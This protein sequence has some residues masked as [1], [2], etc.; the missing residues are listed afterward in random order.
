MVNVTLSLHETVWK[1]MKAHNEIRWSRTVE[2][3]IEGKLDAFDEAQ[4]LAS[5]S[6]LTEKDAA[7]IAAEIDSSAARHAKALLN[8]TR[9]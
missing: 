9:G 7:R 1:R 2:S 6:R 3:V 5:K 4:L 8:E